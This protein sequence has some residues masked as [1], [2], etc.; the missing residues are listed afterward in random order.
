MNKTRDRLKIILIYPPTGSIGVY[1]TPTGLLY[2]ATVLKNNGYDVCFVDCSVEPAYN[3]ILETEIKNADFIGVYAMSVHIRYLLPL[4][5]KLKKINPRIKIIWGGPH[6]A[7][8]PEQT[9]Y[10]F[11]ADIV[12]R[13]EGEEVMLE[14]AQAYECGRLSLNNIKGIHFKEDGSVIKTPD[15][16]FIKMD[17]LPFIDWTF[18]KKEVMEVVKNSIIRI[19][20][21]RGCPFRCAFC[22]N[23]VLNNRK[24][25]YRD[26][27][28]VLDEIKYIYHE[29]NIKRI[30]FRDEVFLS[31]RNQVKNISTGILE[32]GMKLTWFANL[33]PKFFRESYVDDQFLK[34][35]IASG[36]NKIATGAESG[37]QRILDLLRK[38]STVEDV[39][40]LVRRAKKFNILVVTAFMTGIPT[41][42]DEEQL[43]TLRLIREIVRIHPGTIINGP[44]N[45]RPYPGGEL[46]DMCLKKY[47]LRMPNSL[48]EWA[49]ADIL[50]GANPP[51]VKKMYIN[52]YL[53][54]SIT[55]AT[56]LKPWYLWGKIRNNPIKGLFWLLLTI[57]SRLRLMHVF[58]KFP[59]EF[60]L[61]D[62]YYRRII[63]K[64][65]Q[66]S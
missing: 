27:Q 22:I 60:R 17:T 16:D 59:I 21:S 11:Y 61:L 40:N 42:T 66:F 33:H 45:F 4:L 26:P 41:E 2:I 52:Q 32:S 43:Q 54:T 30:G 50:G 18:I 3:E 58:Y 37:S 15:R 28:K 36:C 47:N 10:N 20:T 44:A 56:V 65:P 7:L 6:A 34:L 57:F 38:E 31:N 62:F 35:L 63:K 8:F 1:N 64:I 49:K 25:R 46:Y 19:Q 23:V 24:M 13:G 55:A 29:Y 14:I 12:V 9:A 51:W 5:E 48:E 53:W 39:L